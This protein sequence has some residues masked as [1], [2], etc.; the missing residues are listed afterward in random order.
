MPTFHSLKDHYRFLSEEDILCS[1]SNVKNGA[2][3]AKIFC[4]GAECGKTEFL[5]EEMALAFS[6]LDKR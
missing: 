5:S 4:G 6:S 2:N 3:P 1:F